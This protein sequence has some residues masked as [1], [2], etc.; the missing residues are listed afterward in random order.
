MRH[1]V[2]SA[3]LVQ[4]L[5][6][7]K[8]GEEETSLMEENPGVVFLPVMEVL[9]NSGPQGAICASAAEVPG[10]LGTLDL[11]QQRG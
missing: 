4:P 9:G 10:F 1:W 8:A 2:L 5:L 7:Q 6:C 3:G 11:L